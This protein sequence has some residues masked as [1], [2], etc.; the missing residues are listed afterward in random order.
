MG[1][2]A[3]VRLV[4]TRA[5]LAQLIGALRTQGCRELLRR[6]FCAA[7]QTYQELLILERRYLAM[8]T[9]PRARAACRVRVWHA[10][11]MAL[12]MGQRWR[13]ETVTRA[14]SPPGSLRGRAR[15]AARRA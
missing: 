4:V 13:G 8:A 5:R 2:R 12:E 15:R 10:E 7:E 3:I 14:K 1:G 9:E 6:Q 11:V